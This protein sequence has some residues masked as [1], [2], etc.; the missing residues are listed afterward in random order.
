MLYR[1]TTSRKSRFCGPYWQSVIDDSGVYEKQ[2]ETDPP[3]TT[4]ASLSPPVMTTLARPSH[5]ELCVARRGEVCI[6]Y[7][8]SVSSGREGAQETHLVTS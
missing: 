2:Y 1:F 5:N 4:E 3:I 8:N 7:S 6:I